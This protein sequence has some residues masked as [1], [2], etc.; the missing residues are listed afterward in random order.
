MGDL[1]S[2]FEKPVK[3]AYYLGMIT[4]VPQGERLDLIDGQ[5]RTTVLMLLA[6]GPEPVTKSSEKSSIA[7]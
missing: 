6:I 3:K 2:H 5:Q 7:G 4:V 1:H